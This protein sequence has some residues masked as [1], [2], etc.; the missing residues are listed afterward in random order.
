VP[1]CGTGSLAFSLR[2]ISRGGDR[3]FQRS[4]WLRSWARSETSFRDVRRRLHYV[5]LP[6]GHRRVAIVCGPVGLPRRSG[7]AS[8]V[9]APYAAD[10][11]GA[12]V[13]VMRRSFLAFCAGIDGQESSYLRYIFLRRLLPVVLRSVLWKSKHLKWKMSRPPPPPLHLRFWA[14]ALRRMA[15]SLYLATRKNHARHQRQAD[16]NVLWPHRA[17][18]PIM[19]HL[20]IFYSY[21][22]PPSVPG[23]PCP[24]WGGTYFLR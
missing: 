10:S 22:S 13:T 24:Q 18:I 1:A 16:Q 8:R 14:H 23:G 11:G 15:V 4:V 12:Y 3:R 2:S 9:Q 19:F 7:I 20:L 5:P 21:S 17:T 6:Y